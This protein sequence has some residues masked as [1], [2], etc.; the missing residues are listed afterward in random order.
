MLLF[1]TVSTCVLLLSKQSWAAK[2]K[3]KKLLLLFDELVSKTDIST[4]ALIHAHTHTHIHCIQI[5]VVNINSSVSSRKSP[6]ETEKVGDVKLFQ[7]SS[8][9]K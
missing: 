9:S 5:Q 3:K 6:D 1:V 8:G 4:H 2:K 7:E